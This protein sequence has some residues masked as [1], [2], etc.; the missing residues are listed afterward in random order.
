MNPDMLIAELERALPGFAG[1]HGSSENLHDSG[2]LCSVFAA[3][4]D[5]VREQ[6]ITAEC[7]PRLA[8]VVNSAASDEA[9]SEAACTC[10]LE[11]LADPSH[12]L[13]R[14]L[15]GEALSYWTAW[16]PAG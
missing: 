12:P 14:F 7:W 2:T 13:K 3:C 5:F 1:Y 11:N 15:T 16:E 9:A 4:C 10:F 6:P 8:S